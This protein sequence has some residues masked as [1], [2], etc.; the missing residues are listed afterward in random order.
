MD[1]SEPDPDSRLPFTSDAGMITY[2]RTN[3]IRKPP[4]DRP[5][6]KKL[7]DAV[8]VLDMADGRTRERYLG[9]QQSGPAV[10]IRG[11][12]KKVAEKKPEKMSGFRKV[13]GWV[14]CA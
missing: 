10:D 7:D 4:Q 8:A 9:A 2:L 1:P 6:K 13:G 12:S 14:L 3:R 11:A 5:P